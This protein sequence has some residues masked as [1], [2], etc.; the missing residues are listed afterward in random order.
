MASL[1]SSLDEAQQVILVVAFF[2]KA[3]RLYTWNNHKI[4]SLHCKPALVADLE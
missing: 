3:G 1:T 2:T 4:V